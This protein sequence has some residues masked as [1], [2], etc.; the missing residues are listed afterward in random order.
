M[1]DYKVGDVI[2]YVTFASMPR[3]VVVEYRLDDMK[4][5]QPGF[6]GTCLE[7]ASVWGYDDQ[8]THIIK[9]AE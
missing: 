9:R 5:G 2:E 6:G 8:I 4:N 3:Q 1:N 7:G